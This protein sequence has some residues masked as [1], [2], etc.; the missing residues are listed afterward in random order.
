MAPGAE[1][2]HAVELANA[3]LYSSLLGST[4]ELPLDSAAYAGRLAQL[5]A[6]STLKKTTI[7]GLNEDFT[8]SF[9][10]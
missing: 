2:I 10:R 4:V 5:I 8:Q 3:M 7:A 1:G 6:G 9:K